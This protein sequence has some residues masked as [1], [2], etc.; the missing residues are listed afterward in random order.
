MRLRAVELHGYKSFATREMLRFDAPVTAIVGPNG[1]GKS[2]VMDA[3]RWAIGAGAGRAIRTRRAEDVI[4][5]GGRDRAPSGFAEVRVCLDNRDQWLELDAAEVEIVRRVHRDGQSEHRLNGRSVRLRDVQDLF[6]NS[7]LGTGGFALMSQGLVDEVLRLRPHERRRAIEEVGGVW[8]HRVQMQESRRRRERAQDH[9][10]QARLLREELEPRLRSL[11]RAAR[12]ARRSEQLARQLKEARQEYLQ[13]RA[14]DL[15]T[16]LEARQHET[17]SATQDRTRSEQQQQSAKT[18]LVELEREVARARQDLDEI[19]ERSRQARSELRGL[20]REQELDQQQATWLQREISDLASRLTEQSL[21]A[22]VKNTDEAAAALNALE[23]EIK[24]L[25]HVERSAER[26]RSQALQQQQRAELEVDALH[27]ESIHISRRWRAAA[28]QRDA[29][30]Q[31]V[32]ESATALLASRSSLDS[33]EAAA[34]SARQARADARDAIQRHERE[35]SRLRQQLRACEEQLAQLRRTDDAPDQLQSIFRAVHGDSAATDALAGELAD[36]ALFDTLE[37]ALDEAE[38]QIRSDSGRFAAVSRQSATRVVE[39]AVRVAELVDSTDAALQVAIAGR[40]AV[41]RSGIVVRP[42]GVVLAGGTQPDASRRRRQLA[43]LESEQDDLIRQIDEQAELSAN[44]RSLAEHDQDVSLTTAQLESVQRETLVAERQWQRAQS[45][46]AA[47]AAQ[48]QSARAEIGRLRNRRR[49]AGQSRAAAERQLI[50]LPVAG[51]SRVAELET[52]RDRQADHLAQLRAQVAAYERARDDRARQKTLLENQTKLQ[53]SIFKRQ[54]QLQA[55]SRSVGDSAA[56]TSAEQRWHSAQADRSNAAR[57]LDRAQQVRLQAERRDVAAAGA[58]RETQAAQARLLKEAEEYGVTLSAQRSAQRRLPESSVDRADAQN[59]RQSV[60]A[61]AASAAVAVATSRVDEL[62]DCVADLRAK[63]ERVG[64]VDPDA[65]RQ[66]EEESER[67]RHIELQ[68]ADLEAT[69]VSLT[70]AERK[71][72]HMID[73]A[74]RDACQQ[75]NA[76]FQR[77]FQLMF[78]GGHAELVLVEDDSERTDPEVA[79]SQPSRVGVEIRAQPPGKRVS[80]L[81]LLSG[82]ERALTAIA[83][84][85]ALLEVRPAPFCVLDEVDAAL[86]EANVERFVAALKERA[87]ST[88]FVVITHNR[89]TIEQADS[90]FGVTMGAAGVSRLLSVRVDGLD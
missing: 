43:A 90:I 72:E 60:P 82:G 11:E 66:Y 76:A 28:C 62:R 69:E 56:Q 79:A 1:S 41:T 53:E 70:E 5:S 44:G 59:G 13:A 74:F 38:R 8:Q 12:R 32:Q 40:V 2:N 36:A 50:A 86:D 22:P 14:D 87:K 54:S 85:F 81:G 18:A 16:Q 6:R 34:R 4:F 15:A 37:Q 24:R 65:A 23:D 19:V 78:R 46:H 88:Q 73:R 71:L 9:L 47:A 25:R 77:Y 68:V 20:Q 26:D 75:V 61:P 39:A 52:E 55:L 33:A 10:A 30:R 45:A 27:A 31:T 64:A 48:L 89:R 83:L 7:G 67:W 17:L 57:Q 42:D 84:L 49:Q 58:L 21:D 29:S 51:P 63:L 3:L 80:A 35:A